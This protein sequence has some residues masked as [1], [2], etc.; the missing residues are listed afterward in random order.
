MKLV[1]M[2]QG[3]CLATAALMLCGASAPARTRVSSAS[4][5]VQALGP[6]DVELARIVDGT[7]GTV[8]VTIVHLETGK[9]AS[10]N[11]D[12]RFPMAST[13]KVAIAA[14]ILDQVD[15]G[16]LT[17]DQMI[18]VP[19]AMV[20]DSD[21]IAKDFPHPG[22]SLSVANLIESM[23]V[24]SDNTATDVLFKLA[25]GGQAV[26]AWIRKIGVEGMQV[27]RDTAHLIMDFA[28]I[29]VQPNKRNFAALLQ[30]N[31]EIAKMEDV[32]NPRFDNDPRD[33]ATPDAMV[34]L[35]A[36]IHRGEALSARS[37]KFLLEVMERCFTGQ[38]RLIAMLPPGVALA[39]K[40]GTIGGTV[41]DVGI[42]TLPGGGGH[43]AIAVFIKESSDPMAT[44]ERL[45]A[46]IARTAYDYMQMSITHQPRKNG[47]PH[48]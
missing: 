5:T 44:R 42:M 28:G 25:G 30:A 24:V 29:T 8:G 37:T 4:P 43:L 9:R 32:P 27:D 7:S 17:L 2:F 3:T 33:T 18:V 46:Q 1:T 6:L 41:N 19:E 47:E 14:A 31:P 40:T 12:V 22:V 13:Y 20:V 10:L 34:G 21:G 38:G 26:T 23:L 35:L 15:A 16:K 11:P 39:H 45:I 36:R 48:K